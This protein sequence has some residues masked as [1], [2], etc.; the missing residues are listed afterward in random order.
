MEKEKR[1]SIYSKLNLGMLCK[2]KI[3]KIGPEPRKYSLAWINWGGNCQYSQHMPWFILIIKLIKY[4]W[5]G[6]I[7]H[8]NKELM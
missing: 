6:D 8:V 3:L 7:K 2:S 1:L 4:L 5:M